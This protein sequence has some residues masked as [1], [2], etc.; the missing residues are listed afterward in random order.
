MI[1]V[2][3]NKLL[4][5]LLAVMMVLTLLPTIS[6]AEDVKSQC[7]I[8][9]NCILED[10]HENDC[11]TKDLK[12]TPEP[13]AITE[14]CT[15]E[16]GH[17][18]DCAIEPASVEISAEEKLAKMI[19]ALENIDLM[20]EAQVEII[21]NQLS[22]IYDFAE[23]NGI[24][25]ENNET[26]NTVLSALYST[27]SF[28]NDSE[29]QNL[30]E[31][32][33]DGINGNDSNDGTS[34]GKAVKTL[35]KA[36]E[37]AGSEG[38]IYILG[39]VGL[40]NTGIVDL[41]NVN[42]KRFDTFTGSLIE[43]YGDTTLNLSNMSMD[44]QKANTEADGALVSVQEGGVLNIG[45]GTKLYD[46]AFA[47]VFA[48]S[49][50]NSTA[51]TV[52]MSDG[53]IYGCELPE[54]WTSG[55]TG[56]VVISEN[57]VFNMSGGEIYGGNSKTQGAGVTV[58]LPSGKFY[59]TGGTIRDNTSANAGGGL[60][61]FGYA[62]L[63][64][65]MITSNHAR[66]GGGV[67]TVATGTTVLDGTTITGNITDGNGAGVYL[68]GYSAIGETGECHFIMKSGSIT[69]NTS[70]NGSGG[71][72]YGYAWE[73]ETVIEIKGGT[74]SGNKAV[75]GDAIGLNGDDTFKYAELELSGSPTIEGTVYLWDDLWP[76]IKI[77]VV[78]E[79]SP[80]QPVVL[81]REN[82]TDYRTTVTYAENLTT[83]PDDFA[84]TLPTR[85]Y[86]S[87]QQNL[88]MINLIPVTFQKSILTAGDQDIC[89]IYCKPGEVINPDD[90]PEYSKEGYSL[91]GFV[92]NPVG[93]YSGGRWNME[94]DVVTEPIYIG[95]TWSIN[96]PLFT[97]TADKTTVHMDGTFTLT[98][99]I[100]NAIAPLSNLEWY[101]DGQKIAEVPWIDEKEDDMFDDNGELISTYTLTV[102]ESGTYTVKMKVLADSYNTDLFFDVESNPV[103]LTV[104]QHEISTD[105]ISDDTSHW[106]TCTVDGCEEKFD[107]AAHTG[108]TAGC[109]TKAACDICGAEYGDTLGHDMGE[110]KT[111]ISPSC[112]N[113]GSEQR[114]CNRC[115]YTETRELD[116]NGHDWKDEFTIDKSPTYT[117]DGSK[118][119]HCKNCDA[120]KDSEVI[121][122]I[123]HSYNG[124]K[125][126]ENSHWHEYTISHYKQTATEIPSTGVMVNTTTPSQLNNN[127]P[128]TGD[129]SSIVLWIFL[130]SLSAA[131]TGATLII[132]KKRNN[133]SK[134]MK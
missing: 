120:V 71:G 133:R 33:L 121:P 57:S 114:K 73:Y 42:I 94:T 49:S 98:A 21:Q 12:E 116:V 44:G 89:I 103:L 96:L 37:L 13:C 124:T 64:G 76:N 74:V 113:K 53:E 56:N 79:F 14:G 130:L 7:T 117:E 126:N 61:N 30:T 22:E 85:G 1:R 8:T 105:W 11:V 39:T 19:S 38:I 128:K 70:E 97:L 35:E 66:Y 15:L 91:S 122:A 77:D 9:K 41:S 104:T 95:P 72:I 3:Q 111:V 100:S 6:F 125:Y 88:S 24:N 87:Q 112:T 34:T 54:N 62:E 27:A 109:V 60:L 83:N 115:E 31:I 23:K 46:N 90:I 18:G 5:I 58:N 43:V 68:E 45:T 92:Y 29:K 75:N 65:G 32:F 118:S 55:Y 17:E 59:M 20:D 50:N 67:A 102:S 110:W 108:G 63:N 81:D 40:Q 129:T 25:M 106:H 82:W 86:L 26:V 84:T 99:T 2:K 4:T 47:A 78:D 93:V 127:T 101:K 16:A 123:G 69:N 36:K 10:G 119:I 28:A 48:I 134:Q 52:N 51:A 132:F 131:G 80:T 107:F